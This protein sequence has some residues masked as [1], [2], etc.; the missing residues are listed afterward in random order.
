MAVT[1]LS[2]HAPNMSL[3]RLHVI[4]NLRILSLQLRTRPQPDLTGNAC[5]SSVTYA[6][7]TLKLRYDL[8]LLKVRAG[9]VIKKVLILRGCITCKDATK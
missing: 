5:Y 3:V 2:F 7:N 4:V 6:G 9:I 8:A 1:P